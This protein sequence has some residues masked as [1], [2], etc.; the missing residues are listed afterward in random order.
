MSLSRSSQ[1][2]APLPCPI[3]IVG[4][5][6][7]TPTHLVCDHCEN[8]VLRNGSSMLH[9]MHTVRARLE[10]I[11]QHHASQ[12]GGPFRVVVSSTGEWVTF[13]EVCMGYDKVFF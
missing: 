1:V 3:C 6:K 11:Y 5:L 10:E 4:G 9:S 12:C 7:M 8:F 2:E 13:C